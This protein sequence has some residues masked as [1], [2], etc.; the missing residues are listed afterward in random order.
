MLI[1]KLF[2][3]IKLKSKEVWFQ[4]LFYFEIVN[5]QDDKLSLVVPV[6]IFCEENNLVYLMK[7]KYKLFFSFKKMKYR[8]LYS[9]KNWFTFISRIFH[10]S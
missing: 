1:T 3:L 7:K 5:V 8:K 10:C 6:V 9:Y 4:F 2:W